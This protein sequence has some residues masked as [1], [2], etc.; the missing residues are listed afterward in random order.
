M[1]NKKLEEFSTLI[2]SDHPEQIYQRFLEENSRFVPQEFIQNHGVHFELILRKLSLAKDY[3]CDFFYM[4]KSSATWNCIFVEIEKPQ[5][6]YFRNGTNEFHSDF[7]QALS[8]ITKW[9]AW[10]AADSN[11][12]SFTKNTVGP[13]QGHMADNPSFIKY[14]LVHGRREEFQ[15]NPIRKRMIAANES[16]DFQIL[17]FDSL[18]DGAKNRKQDL[19]VGVRKNEHFEIHS[20]SYA[21]DSIFAWM[22]PEMLRITEA[23]AAD[24]IA[25]KSEWM[26]HDIKGKFGSMTL[27]RVLPKIPRI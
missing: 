3:T 1:L 14:V 4:S 17:S 22:E 20:S 5:S 19:Y 18:L 15:R 2:D 6:K 26:S 23:L 24:I 27:D 12:Q 8:Q 21:G 25:K 13:L 11:L 16:D 9:R 10:F 7:N